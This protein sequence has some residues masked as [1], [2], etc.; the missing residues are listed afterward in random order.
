LELVSE[1]ARDAKVI[2]GQPGRVKFLWVTVIDMVAA[3]KIAAFLIRPVPRE[4]PVVAARETEIATVG[5][6]H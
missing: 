6:K 5:G 4:L 2:E 1:I 3:H